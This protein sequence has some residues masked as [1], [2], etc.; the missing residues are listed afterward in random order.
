MN[1]TN[2]TGGHIIDM[3]DDSQ[4]PT[5]RRG[6]IKIQHGEFKNVLYVPS[7]AANLLYVYQM[8]H[9]GS[10][11]Q[12][13]FGPNSVEITK[14]ASGNTMAKGIGDHASKAYAFSH[15]MPYSDPVQPRLLFEADKGIKTPLLPIADT[16]LLSNISYSDSEEEKDQHDF[17]IEL[18]PQ[19]YLDLDPT[20]TSFKQPKWAQRLI[21]AARNGAG[22]PD[23]KRRTRSQYQK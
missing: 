9:T 11:K 5:S 15:F 22:D 13:L 6:S 10:P 4:I 19:R 14:I 18:T 2:F 12:V 21:E 8:N 23:D 3:G 17:D 16:N 1:K 7:L 20:S